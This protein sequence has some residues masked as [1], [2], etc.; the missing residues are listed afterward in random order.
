MVVKAP[1]TQTRTRRLPLW[2]FFVYGV[3]ALLIADL[4]LALS[5]PRYRSFLVP[6][7]SPTATAVATPVPTGTGTP[8]PTFPAFTP[9]LAPNGQ[10]SPDNPFG[11]PLWLLQLLF[12][13][14]AV[15]GVASFLRWAVGAIGTV[16][17]V[18]AR[19]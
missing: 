16:A 12:G 10:V 14:T 1:Q 3:V 8:V 7:P 6:V 15:S 9:T 19:R 4:L 13:L 2:L 5:P 18:F 17:R 11:L